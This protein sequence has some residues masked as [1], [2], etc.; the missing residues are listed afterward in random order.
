[1]I[2]PCPNCGCVCTKVHAQARG[3]VILRYDEEGLGCE[4]FYEAL[5][6]DASHVVRCEDCGKIRR[7]LTLTKDAICVT[8]APSSQAK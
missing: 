6:F 1:M 4:A 7:D 5:T 2:P 8:P 3:P